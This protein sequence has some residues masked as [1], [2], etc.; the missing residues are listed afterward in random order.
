[1]QPWDVSV[2]EG[3][4]K[5]LKWAKPS[6]WEGATGFG[7]NCSFTEDDTKVISESGSLGLQQV[8]TLVTESWAWQES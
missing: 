1:M 2:R 3:L 5:K 4:I 8:P 6:S 7:V